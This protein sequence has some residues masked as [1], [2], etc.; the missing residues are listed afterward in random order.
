MQSPKVDHDH[1]REHAEPLLEDDRSSQDIELAELHE[2]D[3]LRDR[4]QRSFTEESHEPPIP[5]VPKDTKS[6]IAIA[7][8]LIVTVFSFMVNTES[9]AYFEDVLKWKKPFCTMYITHSSLCLPWIGHVIWSR[10]KERHVPYRAWVKQYNN[11]LRE[12][13]ASIDAYA[14]SGSK[15]IIKR[16][17]NVAGPLDFLASAMGLV[18]VVL[19]VSGCSWFF[20]LAL[21]TPGDLT[22]IYNCSTFFAAA[23]S[24]PILKERL[25]WIAIGA[26][27]MSIIGTFII[28]YGDTTAEHEKS[29]IGTSRLVGNLIASIGAVAF[30]LYEVLFKKWACS[31]RPMSPSASLPLTFAAS[32]LTGIYTFATLWIGLIILHVTGVEEFVWPSAKVGLWIFVAVISGSSK[33]DVLEICDALLTVLVVSINL[34]VVLVVWTGPVFGSMANV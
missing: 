27:A 12:L 21:T 31:S 29:A 17:G 15:F 24:V 4:L 20:S 13:A 5:A 14:T 1:D 11:E 3:P 23:F 32:A 18:T 34:L 10:Y 28:A 33:S 8:A 7:T 9:T 2:E 19:T 25:S 30:G 26:V 16:K 22:A 6:Y